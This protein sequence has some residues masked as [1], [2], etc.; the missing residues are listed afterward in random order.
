MREGVDMNE[1]YG[2]NGEPH[3]PT[4]VNF[5]YEAQNSDDEYIDM[6]Q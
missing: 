6:E 3:E 4:H 1:S 5:E 2:W